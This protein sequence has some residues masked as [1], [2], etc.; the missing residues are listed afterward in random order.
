MNT[1]PPLQTIV[2]GSRDRTVKIWTLCHDGENA[3]C[4]DANRIVD[5]RNSGGSSIGRQG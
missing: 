1:P 5:N 4:G 3:H 2:T